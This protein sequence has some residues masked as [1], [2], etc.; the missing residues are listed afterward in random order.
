[1]TVVHVGAHLGQEAQR[2]RCWG[3]A[4]VVWV[5]A[6]PNIFKRLEAHI[7]E[8]RR[9][10]QPQLGRLLRFPK[11]EHLLINALVGESDEGTR[12][13]HLYDND[14]A[15]NSVFQIDRSLDHRHDHVK[16]VGRTLQLPVRRL[17]TLL[18]QTGVSPETVDVLVIDTQGAEA[19]CLK[20]AQRVLKAARYLE[21]EV[22]VKPVYVGGAALVE[23]EAWLTER[24]FYRK[25][26]VCRNHMNAIFVRRD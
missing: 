21:L 23:L 18:E 7:D 26:M 17:D 10:P 19:L 13:F 16:E 2:Y 4:R 14:G 15:S 3:A 24:H 6:E 5:E 12:E 11:T 20:G 8:V 9:E 22:S 25:T 1:M